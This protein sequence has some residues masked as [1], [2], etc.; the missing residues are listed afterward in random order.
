MNNDEIYEAVSHDKEILAHYGRLG[1]KWYQHIFGDYQGAAKYAEKG[2]KKVAASKQKDS[3]RGGG[4]SEKTKKLENAV[5]A[6]KK[7]AKDAKKRQNDEVEKLKKELSAKD[8]DGDE[9]LDVQRIL[10]MKL[11][12]KQKEEL[13]GM[14][15]NKTADDFLKGQ[16]LATMEQEKKKIEKQKAKEA[17]QAAKAEKKAK[18]EH[19]QK[20]LDLARGK[21]DWRKASADDLLE[22]VGRLQ[23]EQQYKEARDTVSGVKVWKDAGSMALKDIAKNTGNIIKEA[24]NPVATKLMEQLAKDKDFERKK[25]VDKYTDS[26]NKQKDKDKDKE[27]S[28]KESGEST[29]EKPD[30]DTKTKDKKTADERAKATDN[31]SE[32]KRMADERAGMT[33]DSG[34]FPWDRKKKKK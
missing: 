4:K 19:E 31:R 21:A 5:K 33:T 13:L 8:Y 12:K 29:K 18:E 15:S 7:E 23:I 11:P 1:M 24:T 32:D 3:F 14:L 16:R 6:V 20:I 25:E 9:F 26:R 30:K 22:A 27:K 2:A 10:D 17:E 28:Q 34:R